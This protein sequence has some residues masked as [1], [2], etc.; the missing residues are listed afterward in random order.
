MTIR[1]FQWNWW[2]P[3][4][5]TTVRPI[6][7]SIQCGHAPRKG[8]RE[9]QLWWKKCVPPP[10]AALCLFG[11]MNPPPQ[12]IVIMPPSA[13][14]HLTSLDLQSPWKFKL[15]NPANSAA[16][17]YAGVLE[18]IAQ[19][20]VVHLPYWMMKTLRLNEGDPIRITGAELPKGKMVKIQAQ[21]VHFLEVSDPK[22]VYVSKS[23]LTSSWY[24]VNPILVGLNR[25]SAI[26]HVSP[27]AIS[28]KSSTIR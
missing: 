8:A 9:C 4:Q 21:S 12:P 13:L 15:R 25:P 16:S 10:K 5:S 26:F 6:P 1:C 14:A 19:E 11:L 2:P 18:F 23:T 22:A 20:G 3:C 24:Y 28:S 17:T 27:R 7:Q